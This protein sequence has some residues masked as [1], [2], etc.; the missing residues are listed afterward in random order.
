MNNLSGLLALPEHFSLTSMVKE[1]EALLLVFYSQLQDANCPLCNTKS[2]RI[3][4][5]CRRFLQDRPLCEGRV[6]LELHLLRFRCTN[7][8]CHRHTFIEDISTIADAHNRRTKRATLFLTH[9]AF[10]LAGQAGKRVATHSLLSV[11]RSTMIRLIR[12][13]RLPDASCVEVVGVYL[14]KFISHN[15]LETSCLLG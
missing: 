4:S 15:S 14:S 10:E 8:N 13:S 11:S 7:P 2:Y 6:K 9:L 1:E 12:R 3:H 5:K